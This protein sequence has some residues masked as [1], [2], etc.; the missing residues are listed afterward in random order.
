[1]LTGGLRT[2]LVRARQARYMWQKLPNERLEPMRALFF[3]LDQA[4]WFY[5][6][7]VFAAV[8][9]V[10]GQLYIE[11]RSAKTVIIHAAQASPMR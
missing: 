10:V 4:L 9:L 2:R 11:N 1:V 8:M 3:V 7:L 6:Y 5:F